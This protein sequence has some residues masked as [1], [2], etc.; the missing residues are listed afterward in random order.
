MENYIVRIYRRDGTDPNMVAGVFESVEGETE[1]PFTRLESLISLL[2][3]PNDDQPLD[4]ETVMT[5]EQS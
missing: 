1:V 4:A 5:G 3:T 2:A